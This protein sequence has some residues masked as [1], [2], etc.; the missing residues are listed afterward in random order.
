MDIEQFSKERFDSLGLDT[1][2]ALELSKALERY[3]NEQIYEEIRPKIEGIVADLNRLGHDLRFQENKPGC[4]SL[5]D[6]AKDAKGY[7][8]KL[9]LAVDTIVSCGYSHLRDE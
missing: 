9:R 6:D 3:V 5:R 4:V 1:K 7:S 8:C 2:E